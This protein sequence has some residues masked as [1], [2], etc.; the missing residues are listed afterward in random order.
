MA[1]DLSELDGSKGGFQKEQVNPMFGKRGIFL[2]ETFNRYSQ[3]EIK[4]FEGMILDKFRG[5]DKSEYD[6]K[7]HIIDFYQVQLENNVITHF[8]CTE[9][10]GIIPESNNNKLEKIKNES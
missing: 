9:L 6:R 4:R 5:K 7:L 10:V 1:S 3:I 2:R 8:A